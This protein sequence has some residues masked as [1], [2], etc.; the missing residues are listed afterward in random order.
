M[1]EIMKFLRERLPPDSI[2]ANGA[3]NYTLWPQRH[4]QFRAPKTQL[5]STNGSMGYGAPAAI[6]GKIFRPGATVVSFSGDG[7]FLMNGQELA[8]AAQYGIHVVFIVVNNNCYGT[9][10]SHQ[11]RH[12][13]GRPV[14]TELQNPDFAAL[15]RSYRAFG[16][17]VT[18]TQEFPDAFENAL[19]ANAPALI[20]IQTEK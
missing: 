16:A 4:Y 6:A 15:A 13:P 10:R 7:C 12:Y 14:A 2:I 1:D 20:E 3:G 8:T 19:R 9:I 17:T 5:A 11:Q 18:N